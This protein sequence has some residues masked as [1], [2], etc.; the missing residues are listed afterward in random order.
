MLS[1]GVFLLALATTTAVSRTQLD[2]LIARAKSLE[3]DTIYVPP[4][5]DAMAMQPAMPK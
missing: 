2:E 1:F 5:G 4:P 3:L